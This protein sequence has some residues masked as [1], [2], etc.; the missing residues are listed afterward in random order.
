LFGV[1]A[2]GNNWPVQQPESPLLSKV[3]KPFVET[4]TFVYVVPPKGNANPM[5]TAGLKKSSPET[6]DVPVPVTGAKGIVDSVK[7]SA[8]AVALNWLVAV[9]LS[10]IVEGVAVA[11]VITGFGFTITAVVP[12]AEQMPKVAVNEYVPLAAAVGE[13]ML[14]FCT[15]LANAFGPV[16][17]NVVPP[18]E[19]PVRF[20]ALPAQIG[21]LLDAEAVGVGVTSVDTTLETFDCEVGVHV[22]TAWK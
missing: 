21:A 13:A 3:M 14:G 10:Q 18:T 8:G 5:G 16:H 6:G 15:A 7:P 2:L 11:L 19:V 12:V 4:Y 9:P 1:K 20:N 17:A 22:T